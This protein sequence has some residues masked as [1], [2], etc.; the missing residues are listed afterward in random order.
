[1]PATVRASVPDVV[2]GE[3]E[4]LTMPPVNV[5]AT[6]VTFPAGA[7]AHDAVVPLEVSR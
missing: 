3:P 6:L 7:A 2:I 1:M 5:W 4:T